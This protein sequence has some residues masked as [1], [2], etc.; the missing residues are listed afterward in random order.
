VQELFNS[1]TSSNKTRFIFLK[2]HYTLYLFTPHQPIT[3]KHQPI[4]LSLYP[5]IQN[6]PKNHQQ[7]RPAI[8]PILPIK[9]QRSPQ[10]NSLSNRKTIKYSKN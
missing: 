5:S 2:N 9:K 7:Q 6:A 8:D 3:K 4:H 1:S 10:K